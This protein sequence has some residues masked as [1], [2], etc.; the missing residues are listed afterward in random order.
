MK[1]NS[2]NLIQTWPEIP[3][4]WRRLVCQTLSKVLVILSATTLVAPDLLTLPP[5]LPPQFYQ[6]IQLFNK[7]QL[8]KK[9]IRHVRNRKKDSIYHRVISKASLTFI[10][11]SKVLDHVKLSLYYIVQVCKIHLY[12]LNIKMSKPDKIDILFRHKMC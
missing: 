10:R 12:M 5:P 11:F 4:T 3:K 7:L 2:F 9:I 6:H 1:K 8:N